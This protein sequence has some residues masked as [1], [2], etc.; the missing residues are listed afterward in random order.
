M[1]FKAVNWQSPHLK[2]P[3]KQKMFPGLKRDRLL[4]CFKKQLW[5]IFLYQPLHL[6]EIP[7]KLPT[8]RLK[9]KQT[10]FVF[11][12][13]RAEDSPELKWSERFTNHNLEI[14]LFRLW[15]SLPLLILPSLLKMKSFLDVDVDVKSFVSLLLTNGQGVGVGNSAIGGSKQ[16]LLHGAL[17]VFERQTLSNAT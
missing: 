3:Y 2:H 11:N 14:I 15:S 1:T 13:S 16:Q 9:T 4:Y 6:I 10:F 8:D 17:I 12:F 7:I 5:L